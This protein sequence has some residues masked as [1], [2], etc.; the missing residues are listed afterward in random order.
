M[1]TDFTLYSLNCLQYVYVQD[2]VLLRR[3]YVVSGSTM[4]EVK[5]QLQLRPDSYNKLNMTQKAVQYLYTI[6]IATNVT[7]DLW[8]ISLNF[9]QTHFRDRRRYTF[10]SRRS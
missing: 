10:N 7:V 2:R 9:I 8:H 5:G 6:I 3:A 1:I 4:C